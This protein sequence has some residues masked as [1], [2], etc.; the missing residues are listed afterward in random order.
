MSEVYPVNSTSYFSSNVTNGSTEND[1]SEYFT[2]KQPLECDTPVGEGALLEFITSG[3]LLNVVGLFG[4]FGNIISMII[5]SRPQMKSSINYLLIGLAR[6]DTVLILTSVFL[7]GLPAIYPQTNVLFNYKFFVFPR[8]VKFLYP[9][10][11]IAQMVSVYLTLT[12]TMERY[13]AVCHPLRARSMCTYGRARMAVLCIIV[14]SVIYNIPKF[15]EMTITEEIHW[16]Y[17]VPVYCANATKMRVDEL[18][19]TIYINWMYFI[20]YYAIPFT[21]LTWFNMEIYRQVRKANRELQN[22]SHHQRREI[23]LATMLLCVVIVF[24]VCNIIPLATNICETFYNNIPM[25]L[26]QIGNLMVTINSS[27]NFIIYVIFGRKFKR[28]FLRLFCSSHIFGAG[29]DSPEFPTNDES[30]VTNVTNIELRNSIR[31]CQ[32]HRSSTRNSRNN[33]VHLSNG[34]SHSRQSPKPKVWSATP[35]PCVYYP[36]QSPAR[37]PSQMSR[38]LS[39]QNGW[40]KNNVMETVIQ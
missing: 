14:V 10:A 35:A 24:I 32:V 19:R 21:L 37:S 18:Y 6:C 20:F 40:D 38:T 31:R 8:L 1:T 11:T 3:I 7:F 15:W 27:V 33:N 36:A 30:V 13:V 26:V 23:G 17:K 5:L 39:G 22:L 25:W 29:R 4:L 28:I 34:N 9:L 12:V 2:T 16:K